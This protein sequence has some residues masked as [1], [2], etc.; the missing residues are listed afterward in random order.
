MKKNKKQRE[1]VR[2]KTG[3][4]RN[5]DWKYYVPV[6]N[7]HSSFW[8]K[9]LL[10]TAERDSIMTAPHFILFIYHWRAF[11]KYLINLFIWL[12]F[13]QF[14]PSFHYR[15]WVIELFYH[16]IRF[17]HTHCVLFSPTNFLKSVTLHAQWLIFCFFLLRLLFLFQNL[18][19]CKSLRWIRE[20]RLL[21]RVW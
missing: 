17:T 1:R 10:K 3:K 14:N 6:S 15:S 4:S 12:L 18:F 20:Y 5:S 2:N 7:M 8:H 11:C 21:I 9:Y 13:Q 16:S 19:I